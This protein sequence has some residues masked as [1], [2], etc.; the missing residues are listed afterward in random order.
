M[1]A[2]SQIL[3]EPLLTPAEVAE[4]FRVDAKT[5]TRWARAGTLSSIRTPGG[6][7]RYFERE[8]RSLLDRDRQERDVTAGNPW[9]SARRLT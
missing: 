8:V 5:V 9:S 7:R 3:S 6:H 1:T 4:L 2:R